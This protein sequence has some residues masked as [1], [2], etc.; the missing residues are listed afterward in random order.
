MAHTAPQGYGSN[1][2]AIL[3]LLR[4]GYAIWTPNEMAVLLFHAERSTAAGRETDQHSASQ[5]MEGIYSQR[6]LDWVRGPAGVSRATWH[7]ANAE[8]ADAG[9]LKRIRR[10]GRSGRFEATE[11]EIDWLAVRG[12]VGE[13]KGGMSQPETRHV[14]Q[15]DNGC[16]T[17][18]HQPQVPGCLTVRQPDDVGGMS[19]SETYS[20]SQTDSVYSRSDEPPQS[21]AAVASAIE[22]ATG[23][24]PTD[25][26]TNTILQ[27]AQRLQLPDAITVK[28]ISEKCEEVRR[29]GYPLK[30]GLLKGA[31]E[32][33][34]IGWCNSNRRLI[35]DH[36][37]EQ[38]AATAQARVEQM[39]APQPPAAEPSVWDLVKAELEKTVHP[40]SYENWIQRA[41]FAELRDGVLY[42]TTPDEGTASFIREEYQQRADAAARAVDRTIQRVEFTARQAERATA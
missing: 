37:A 10:S 25:R 9:V 27:I 11:F 12:K 41:Q 2:A 21:A 17:V 42:L 18:R 5:A 36:E 23:E 8:L 3:D 28:W 20:Q 31:A 13:W 34:L 26:L 16:L 7:R 40:V 32:T 30:A 35:A 29:R 6:R 19:H 4:F 15:R 14:S 22:R 33:E 24:K 38:R 39:P 1:Y